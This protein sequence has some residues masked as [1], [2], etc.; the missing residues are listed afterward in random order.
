MLFLSRKW[1][2]NKQICSG[3]TD[4]RFLRPVSCRCISQ[5]STKIRT[6]SYS[7]KNIPA[8]G[9]SPIWNT[10]VRSHD[11]DEFVYAET[12]L[13]GIKIYQKIISEIANV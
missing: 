13:D 8:L 6:N 11:H 10:P 5:A 7:Q 3:G 4:S 2:I 12:Y 1:K 9:F